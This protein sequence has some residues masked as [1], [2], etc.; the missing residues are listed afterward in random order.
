MHKDPAQVIEDKRLLALY[1]YWDSKRGDQTL[2]ARA[3]ID[4]ADIPSLLSIVILVDISAAGEYRYRLVG[5][6]IVRWLGRDITDQTFSEALPSGPY[7][8]FITS[9]VCDAASAGRPLY[10]EGAFIIEGRIDRQVRRLVLPLSAD[11]S[12][13]N[14]ALCGQTIVVA[15]KGALKTSLTREPPF[16]ERHREFLD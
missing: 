13:V 14:M 3:N 6:E 15:T 10:S 11:G 7:S 1:R 4:P 16:T 2:P 5:T 8:D 12:T 9:L